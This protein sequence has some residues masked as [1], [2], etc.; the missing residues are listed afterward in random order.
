MW[1]QLLLLLF[2]YSLI[3]FPNYSIDCLQLKTISSSISSPFL[4]QSQS[5]SSSPSPSSIS[6][7]S[8][9]DSD[10]DLSDNSINQMETDF[11]ESNNETICLSGE[12]RCND[13]CIEEV[14]RCDTKPDCSDGLDE[15]N[16]GEY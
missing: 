14:L 6:P 4:S 11:Y 10:S 12:F 16:C 1:N 9:S 13:I 7:S 15:Q 5:E 3:L 2:S 8:E